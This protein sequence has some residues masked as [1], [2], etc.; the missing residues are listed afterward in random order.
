MFYRKR[1]PS[2]VSIFNNKKVISSSK[3]TLPERSFPFLLP[4]VT[5]NG[6]FIIELILRNCNAVHTNKL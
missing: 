2:V 5:F 1:L 6:I 3:K 4:S